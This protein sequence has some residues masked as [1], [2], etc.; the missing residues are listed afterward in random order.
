MYSVTENDVVLCNG[1]PL[2]CHN[3]GEV[4]KTSDLLDAL[5]DNPTDDDFNFQKD[6]HGNIFCQGCA[7]DF[8]ECDDC[9]KSYHQNDMIYLSDRNVFVCQDCVDDH[10]VLCDDCREYVHVDD[11]YC[12]E[13]YNGDT[14]D[15]CESCAEDYYEC[16]GCGYYAHRDDMDISNDGS[17]YCPNCREEHGNMGIHSYHYSNDP[18]YNMDYLGIDEREQYPMIGVEL[19]VESRGDGYSTLCEEADDVRSNI[20]ND[21]VVTCSDCSLTD[22]FEIISCPANLKHHKETLNWEEGLKYLRGNGFRSHNGGHCGLHTHIDRGYFGDM[23]MDDVEAMFF[24]SFRNNMEWIKLFSRRRN[25]DYCQPNGYDDYEVANIDKFIAPPSKAWVKRKKQG[26]RY[27]AINFQPENTI[28]V[29]IFRGTLKFETFMATLEF[30]SLWAYIV[31]RSTAS[32]ICNVDLNTFKDIAKYKGYKY[33]L[34]YVKD[35]VDVNDQSSTA[36]QEGNA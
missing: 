8:V 31:K 25:Y 1:R 35:R 27:C 23:D 36:N 28:E 18:A 33:F 13:L 26:D 20:G 2:R 29:R 11:S 6:G 5:P 19:E 16:D 7:S 21:Y 9:G 22:G 14:V 32:N 3:C 4:I 34:D 15:L 12:Y 24:V 17:Y 10:Y 30:V